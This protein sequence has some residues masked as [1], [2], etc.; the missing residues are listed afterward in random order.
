MI[1]IKRTNASD[2]DFKHLL[3]FLD[4][5]LEENDGDEHWFFAQFNKIDQIKHVVMVY[6]DKT[7]IGCGALKKYDDHRI[8]V[9]RVFVAPNHRNKGVASTLMQELE[10]WAKSLGFKECILETGIKQVEAVSLYPK[11]G[12][13]KIENYEPYI[14]VLQSVCFSKSL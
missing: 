3:T 14:G 11:L 8:E 7:P 2:K 5:N 10:S 9:K 1:T 4:A 6:A 12:Y 13:Q